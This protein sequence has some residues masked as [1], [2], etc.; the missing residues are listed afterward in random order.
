MKKIFSLTLALI[1]FLC[2]SFIPAKKDEISY[3]VDPSQTNIVW[4]GKKVTGIHSGSLK[5]KEGYVTFKNEK[6]AGGTFEFDMT[7][8]TVSDLKDPNYNS[9]LVNHLK[10]DD[11]FSVEKFPTA[12]FEIT[13]AKHLGKNQYAVTGKLTIKG[14]TKEVMFPAF[15]SLSDNG[16]AVAIITNKFK[17]DRTQFEI[18]YGSA[19]FFDSLGDKAID[20]DF[21]LE[22]TQMVARR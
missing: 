14:I 10:S 1:S 18:K 19:S 5:L 22:V 2:F 6:L 20:N 4:F 11:F 21:E 9:K 3:K 7:S 17:V 13:K 12:K 16:G 8:I 15:V